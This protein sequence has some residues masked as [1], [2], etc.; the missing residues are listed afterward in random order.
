MIREA[1]IDDLPAVL[2]FGYQFY[3]A[4]GFGDFANYDEAKTRHFMQQLIEQPAGV[5]LFNDDGMV[6]AVETS[7][8]FSTTPMVQE[9]FWWLDPAARGNGAGR[10][11]R[12]ALEVWTRQRGTAYLVMSS[13]DFGAGDYSRESYLRAG[14]APAEHTFIGR[15]L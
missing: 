15:V 10:A 9:M 2:E 13:I 4:S 6:G 3:R 14:Y 11:L 8:F 1:T 12:Q 7:L 5:I